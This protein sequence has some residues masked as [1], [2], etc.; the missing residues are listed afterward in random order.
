MALV[1]SIQAGMPVCFWLPDQSGAAYRK[2]VGSRKV[3]A[4]APATPGAPRRTVVIGE[5]MERRNG[6][7]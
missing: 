6:A 1:M 5:T 7:R 4:A 2:Y 3:M